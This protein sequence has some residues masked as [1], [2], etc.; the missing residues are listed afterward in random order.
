MLLVLRFAV[1]VSFLV[2][3]G[4]GFAGVALMVEC[5]DAL[6]DKAAENRSRI[7]AV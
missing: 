6:V 4:A 2:R 5:T 7:A 1:L 3:S